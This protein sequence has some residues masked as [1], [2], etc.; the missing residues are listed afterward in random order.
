MQPPPHQIPSSDS[1]SDTPSLVF[2]MTPS[3]APL[4]VPA[5]VKQASL[6]S[7]PLLSTGHL[8]IK[9]IHQFKTT[10]CCYFSVKDVAADEHVG[11]IIYNF[12]SAAVQS[13][14]N[15]N[16]A[17]LVALTF[18][19]FLIALKKKFLPHLWEDELVQDQIVVQNLSLGL[20]MFTTPM[21]NLVLPSH[22]IIF[23]IIIS[24]F[25]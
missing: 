13:W 5:E 4:Y 19:E 11:K 21:T 2:T 24:A 16:E 18:P 7:V 20:T 8:T 17:Q 12:E 6:S 9:V 1:E 22:C 14:I 25:I 3:I 15:A 23:L 10:C